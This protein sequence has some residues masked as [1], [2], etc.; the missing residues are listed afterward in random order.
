[1]PWD[2]S[3]DVQLTKDIPGS[4]GLQQSY[5]SGFPLGRISARTSI[6]TDFQALMSRGTSYKAFLVR[7]VPI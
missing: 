7:P 5:S 1:M 6:R 3:L 2:I 4:D